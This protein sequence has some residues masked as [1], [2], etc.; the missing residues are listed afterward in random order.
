MKVEESNSIDNDLK[1]RALLQTIYALAIRPDGWGEV[2][3]SLGDAIGSLH[4]YV[5]IIQ[6]DELKV[7]AH[8]QDSTQLINY[9]NYCLN[10]YS[11]PAQEWPSYLRMAQEGQ[12][13]IWNHSGDLLGR[14]YQ[15]KAAG[16]VWANTPLC[17]ASLG[18]H[19]DLDDSTPTLDTYCND[20]LALAVRHLATAL[21]SRAHLEETRYRR[22]TVSLALDCLPYGV[23]LVDREGLITEMNRWAEISCAQ[24]GPLLIDKSGHLVAAKTTYQQCLREALSATF[25]TMQPTTVMICDTIKREW[26]VAVTAILPLLCVEVREQHVHDLSKNVE[27]SCNLYG[28]SPAERKVAHLLAKGMSSKEISLALHLTEG[29]VQQYAHRLFGKLGVHSQRE[30]MCFFNNTLSAIDIRPSQE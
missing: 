1:V 25:Q 9:Q 8:T 5:V 21:R 12:A 14:R 20:V 4:C 29:T 23:L 11:K 18:V 3:A 26:Q 6:G 13:S 7:A 28:V 15:H 30:L 17:L 27:K 19:T 2:L 16:I 22:E 24:G 10:L